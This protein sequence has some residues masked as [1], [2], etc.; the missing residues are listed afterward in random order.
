VVPFRKS[1][2]IHAPADAD[3][4]PAARAP[5]QIPSR[6]GGVSCAYFTNPR[7]A[8]AIASSSAESVSEAA[9][10][11]ISGYLPVRYAI[12]QDVTTN[13]SATNGARVGLQSVYVT[14]G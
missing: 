8:V 12:D 2:R 5:R 13:W 3:A 9:I 10:L 11:R 1:R 6:Y 4:I 14:L 7:I